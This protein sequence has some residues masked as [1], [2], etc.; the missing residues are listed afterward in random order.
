M[1]S[2]SK[3]NYNRKILDLT[4]KNDPRDFI[5]VNDI[6]KG[7]FGFGNTG[8]GK[9]SGAF[10]TLALG[11]LNLHN[12]KPHEKMGMVIYQFKDDKKD[13]ERWAYQQGREKDLIRIGIEHKNVFNPLAS[14]AKDEPLNAVEMLMN[15]ATLSSGGGTRKK[16]E[17]FWE[18]AQKMRLDRM[19]RLMKISGEPFNFNTLNRLH[20][21]FPNSPEQAND[22]NFIRDSY[23]LQTMWKAK[24]RVGDHNRDFQMVDRYLTSFI[25]LNDKTSSSIIAM[26][27][28]VIE[29]F[30]ASR[31]L[32]NFFAGESTLNLN[33]IFSGKI[34]LLDIPVAKYN[35]V[36]RIA[37]ILI[38]AAIKDAAKKRD[39]DS[40]PNPLVFF[41]DECTNFIV[42]RM[43]SLFMSVCRGYGVGN[44]LINQ[45]TSNMLGTIGSE[46]RAAEAQVNSI[47]ALCNTK[48]ANANNCHITNKYVSD[49]IGKDFIRTQ[50]YSVGQRMGNSASANQALHYVVEP[51][52][53]TMGL[54]TGGVEN[55]FIVDALVTRTGGV[56]SNG[57]NF[58]KAS[59]KQHFAM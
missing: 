5:T 43:D 23:F 42:P 32:N 35:Y 8:S 40:Y 6:C 58:I 59:F 57:Q 10:A 39:L 51:R 48:I 44:V 33:E 37:Q 13:W 52:F 41:I 17:E 4:G 38:G 46:G 9:S 11:L 55:D 49:T 53:Y 19:M 14:F 2:K 34:L 56:F 20:D 29:P 50:S 21:S 7:I 36:G 31:V 24:E 47:L 18:S 3:F 28:S 1:S 27:S 26:T 22:E 30:I 12:V 54:R 15:L 25:N 16:G 45:N